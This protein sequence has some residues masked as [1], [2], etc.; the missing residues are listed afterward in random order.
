MMINTKVSSRL[1]NS[2]APCIPSS[3]WETKESSV[4][5]GQVGQPRPEPVNRT[6]PPVTTIPMLATSEATAHRGSA[7]GPRTSR[8]SDP[9]E[10][11]PAAS[12][13]A[14]PARPSRTS[15][16][17]PSTS[18]EAAAR[19]PSPS[20][21]VGS[22]QDGLHR[23]RIAVKRDHQTAADQQHHIDQ[24]GQRQGDLGSQP[25]GQEPGPG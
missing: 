2:M 1:P 21:A 12:T 18:P 5:R 14:R 15:S 25:A 4:Q 20:A 23:V 10:R 22:A 8:A 16:G 24:V 6:R 19:R 3:G 11:L 17:Q 13:P 9:S 7:R